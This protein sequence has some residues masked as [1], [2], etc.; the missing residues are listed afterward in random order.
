[1]RKPGANCSPLVLYTEQ[2]R[3]IDG[4][5]RKEEREELVVQYHLYPMR[6][7]DLSKYV[8]WFTVGYR[9]CF[10]IPV[11]TAGE[12]MYVFSP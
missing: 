3:S 9:D 8:A 4:F 10:A 11:L 7:V 2:R 6:Q 1:M 12:L 5:A